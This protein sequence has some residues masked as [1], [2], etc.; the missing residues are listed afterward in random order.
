[1]NGQNE[2]HTGLTRGYPE[3]DQGHHQAQNRL[4]P[5]LLRPSLGNPATPRFHQHEHPAHQVRTAGRS[6]APG[7]AGIH[8]AVG[9]P[10][11][12]RDRSASRWGPRASPEHLF[13]QAT[14]QRRSGRSAAL[15]PGPVHQPFEL[16]PRCRGNHGL[17]GRRITSSHHHRP[18]RPAQLS[19]CTACSKITQASPRSRRSTPQRRTRIRCQQRSS[20]S[21]AVPV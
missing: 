8:C 1:M 16:A 9:R 19:A 2:H 13:R 15:A 4:R 5:P 17:P 11:S 10:A 6:R 21:R 20:R 3:Q 18:N 7:R 14:A 12:A